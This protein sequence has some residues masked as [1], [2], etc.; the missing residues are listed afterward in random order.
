MG[1]QVFVFHELRVIVEFES[2]VA[3]QNEVD[4]NYEQEVGGGCLDTDVA[5]DVDR[6]VHL[7][8]DVERE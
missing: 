1:L 5:Q 4:V 7:Q 8:Q 3:R 6:V 2:G